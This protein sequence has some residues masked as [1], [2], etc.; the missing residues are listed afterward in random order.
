MS[1]TLKTVLW[2]IFGIGIGVVGV[3]YAIIPMLKNINW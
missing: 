1:K 2:I 3:F